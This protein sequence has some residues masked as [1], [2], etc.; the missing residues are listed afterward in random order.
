[1]TPIRDILS[2]AQADAWLTTWAKDRV[3]SAGRCLSA[4]KPDDLQGNVNLPLFTIAS[5]MRVLGEAEPIDQFEQTIG[6]GIAQALIQSPAIEPLLPTHDAISAYYEDRNRSGW[7][8]PRQKT[9][10]ELI[11]P[12]VTDAEVRVCE[13]KRISSLTH[14]AAYE[15]GCPARRVV[16]EPGRY[17][18]Y[19]GG[20][21][22]ITEKASG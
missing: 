5:V 11:E 4:T 3:R 13:Y 2:A 16:C 10:S 20:L 9:A 8:H 21:I 6:L 1:M 14:M 17:C 7:K 22:Q 18:G 15:T 12:P 19:C